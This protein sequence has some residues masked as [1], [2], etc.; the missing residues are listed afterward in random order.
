MGQKITLIEY[1]DDTYAGDDMDPDIQHRDCHPCVCGTKIVPVQPPADIEETARRIEDMRNYAYIISSSSSSSLSSS[2]ETPQEE[3]FEHHE[4]GG[5]SSY[6]I[7]QT[8][9]SE[10]LAQ[11]FTPDIAHQISRVEL[12]LFD[13]QGDGITGDI[14]VE[15][16]A[17]D[18]NGKPTGDAL[19]TGTIDAADLEPAHDSD[20]YNSINETLSSP[21]VTLNEVCFSID[22]LHMYAVGYHTAYSWNGIFHYTLSTA[23]D[24]TTAS[25]NESLDLSALN[26]CN[27]ITGVFIKPDGTKLY[28]VGNY[29]GGAGTYIQRYDLSTPYYLTGYSAQTIKSLF[30]TTGQYGC[31][32]NPAGTRLFTADN[33]NDAIFQYNLS[34]PW[35]E[36]SLS[37]TPS[38][39]TDVSGSTNA[40]K[41]VTFNEDGT[42]MA[43]VDSQNHKILFWNV[44]T[45]FN[46]SG[47]SKD[48]YEMDISGIMTTPCGCYNKANGKTFWVCDGDSGALTIYQFDLPAVHGDFHSA[49]MGEGFEFDAATKYV[50][51]ATYDNYEVGVNE[52]EWVNNSDGDDN[53]DAGSMLRHD[54][55]NWFDS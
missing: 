39:S 25:L 27:P 11:T 36:T 42:Y 3:L 51:E 35:D 2:S 45:A 28:I 15:I 37:S 41:G 18:V 53:Y 29:T 38:Q 13:N 44:P 8:G 52:P 48:S 46:L 47:E 7:G 6:T 54:G 1:D 34:I 16:K 49:D 22:G 43:V 40:P 50:I 33:Y 9:Y 21:S 24:V 12:E 19:A 5:D 31:W 32:F 4:T 26:I 20:E 55:S 14:D 23:W 17:T 10:I 30:A